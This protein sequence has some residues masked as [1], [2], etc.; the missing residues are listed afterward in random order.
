MEYEIVCYR[1]DQDEGS[2]EVIDTVTGSFLANFRVRQE[3]SAAER[4]GVAYR[5][6]YRLQRSVRT[7]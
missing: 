4:D 5:Y 3:N 2:D 7:S 1:L 6:Y